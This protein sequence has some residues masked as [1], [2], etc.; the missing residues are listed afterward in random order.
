MITTAAAS[1]SKNLAVAPNPFYLKLS[2]Q[3]WFSAYSG[4]R[5]KLTRST[6]FVFEEGQ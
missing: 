3:I 6:E 2:L 4:I 5:A 1:R